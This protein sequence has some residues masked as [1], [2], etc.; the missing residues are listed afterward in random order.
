MKIPCYHSL[1]YCCIQFI[2]NR[3]CNF[4][5]YIHTDM[6]LFVLSLQSQCALA[7]RVSIN[8]LFPFFFLNFTLHPSASFLFSL[9]S[10]T[11][12]IDLS[13]WD[14]PQSL[15]C[16]TGDSLVIERWGRGREVIEVKNLRVH[17][18]MTKR[19]HS[20]WNTL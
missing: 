14:L 3:K 11:R 20:Q 13:D 7:S 12:Y 9:L 5:I 16:L 1:L 8:F 15:Y 6:L 2:H 18:K 4:S 19:R 10:L 17:F